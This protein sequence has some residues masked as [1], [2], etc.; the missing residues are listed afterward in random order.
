[1]VKLINLKSLALICFIAVSIFFI[2]SCYNTTESSNAEVNLLDSIMTQHGFQYEDYSW[3]M[4]KTEFFKKSGM[5]PESS[6]LSQYKTN[7]SYADQKPIAF[8]SP[9]ISMFPIFR[10]SDDK[11]VQVDLLAVYSNES[12]FKKAA[13]ALKVVLDREHIPD[14]GNTDFLNQIPPAT[15]ASL[16]P[17]S[18]YGSDG[19]T[20]MQLTSS[21]PV[22]PTADDP[23]KYILMISLTAAR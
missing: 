6:L 13:E 2:T 21:H 8:G 16:G 18:W 3:A 17:T 23:E 11:L 12:D 10:F 20:M 9:D 22:K 14:V 15:G 1:M 7:Q 5:D 4:T 19:K